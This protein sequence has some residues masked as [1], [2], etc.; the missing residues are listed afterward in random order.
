[1]N[2]EY[3][4][5][6]NIDPYIIKSCVHTFVYSKVSWRPVNVALIDWGAVSI[7]Q[8]PWA[9]HTA[10]QGCSWLAEKGLEIYSQ[11]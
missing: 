8:V 5:L 2:T 11:R 3:Q 1:M 10:E 4:T 6:L 7:S 9:P